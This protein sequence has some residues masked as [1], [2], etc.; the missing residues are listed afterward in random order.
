M[1]TETLEYLRGQKSIIT[2][3][4]RLS[5]VRGCD[6]LLLMEEGR[7]VDQGNFDTLY[8]SNNRFKRMVDLSHA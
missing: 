3:A 2:V 6:R 1:I 7:I 8:Q 5:T 4:H